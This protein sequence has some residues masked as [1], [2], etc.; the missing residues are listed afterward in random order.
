MRSFSSVEEFPIDTLIWHMY[1][2]GTL[3][4]RFVDATPFKNSSPQG[5]GESKESSTNRSNDPATNVFGKQLTG[6]G[7]NYHG[8]EVMYSGL[9][10]TEFT[11]E[12]YM[13]VVYYQRLRHMVSDKYQVVSPKRQIFLF[14]SLR[15]VVWSIKT[16]ARWPLHHVQQDQPDE[17]VTGLYLYL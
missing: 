6:Y 9:L 5:G 15:L 12:I 2:A 16:C 1:Q 17:S 7:F 4:G 13:G 11:C 8:T 10:G 3:G 14:S